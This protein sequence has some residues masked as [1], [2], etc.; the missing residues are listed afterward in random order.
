MGVKGLL[1]GSKGAKDDMLVLDRH[2]CYKRQSV[3][4]QRRDR[5]D[6][7]LQYLVRRSLVLRMINFCTN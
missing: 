4:A 3:N 1:E 7:N 5:H 6:E 2:W